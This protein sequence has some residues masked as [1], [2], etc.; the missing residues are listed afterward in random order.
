M[1]IDKQP[2]PVNVIELTDEN[3]LFRPDIANKDKDKK[4]IIIGDPCMSK[5]SQGSRQKD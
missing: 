1:Q 4:N 3:V 5:T 2:F